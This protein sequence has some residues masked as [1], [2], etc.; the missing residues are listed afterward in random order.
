MTSRSLRILVLSLAGI[1]CS[2]PS[3]AA[4]AKEACGSCHPENRV[5]TE[6]SVHLAEGV[7][8]VSCHGGDP[9]SLRVETAHRGDFRPLTNRLQSPAMCAQCHSD[10]AK[11]R[12]YNLPIDQYAIYLTSQH[13]NAVSAGDPRAAVCSDC[14]GFHD[15]RKTTDPLNP[16]HSANVTATCAGCHADRGLMAKY[17][18]DPDVVA[19][20]RSSVH[21]RVLLDERNSAAPD[22]TSCHGSHGP[23]PPGVGDIDKICGSC[24]TKTRQAFLDGPHNQAMLDAGLPECASCHSNHAIR[25]FEV[26]EIESLCADCHGEG[27]EQA[28]LGAKFTNL[29]E[30]TREEL[31]EADGLITQAQRV[32]LNVEDHIGRLEEG[33]T[34]L[35]EAFPQIHSVSLDAV[36]RVTRRSRSIGS[37]I[38]HELYTRL[39]RRVAHATLAVFWFYLLMTVAILWRYRQKLA[40]AKN[41]E[42]T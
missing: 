25:R 16:V 36:E 1:A 28:A 37:E 42:T 7:T 20:Y 10:L 13:G 3:F 41:E 40:A 35:T 4:G 38:Q 33:R 5:E 23:T 21:A 14:H 19:E 15:V 31:V 30:S 8:C 26:A 32:P 24:H 9:E 27:S 12:P 18:I 6:P 2:L 29:I 22:C 11:M 39:D 34:F 17:D